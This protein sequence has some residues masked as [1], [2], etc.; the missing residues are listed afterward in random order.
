MIRNLYINHTGFILIDRECHSIIFHICPSHCQCFDLF[1][2]HSAVRYVIG[3]GLH[4]G[5]LIFCCNRYLLCLLK[6]QSESNCIQKAVPF[7]CANADFPCRFLSILYKL[8][9]F[10]FTDFTFGF[11]CIGGSSTGTIFCFVGSTARTS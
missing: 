1:L 3:Y 7:V 10:P 6:E 5:F 8:S 2:R 4:T 11:F 9:I